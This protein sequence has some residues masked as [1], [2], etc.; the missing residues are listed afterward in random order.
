MQTC[1]RMPQVEAIT[2]LKRPTIYAHIKAGIFPKPIKIGPR[3]VAWPD[4]SLKL[5]LDGRSRC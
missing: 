4:S 5:W 1:Y 2:G 3:A